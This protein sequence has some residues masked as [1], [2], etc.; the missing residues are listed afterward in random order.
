M[1]GRSQLDDN[2]ARPTGRAD[3]RERIPGGVKQAPDSAET[4]SMPIRGLRGE[5]DRLT[6]WREKPRC[7]E[8]ILRG[9]PRIGVTLSSA[10]GGVPSPS[11]APVPGRVS[12]NARRLG[13]G[14][15]M[16]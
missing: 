13:P 5:V 16:G 15:S 10:R 11:T 3:P 6:S 8:R 2:P 14:H 7:S 12:W 1:A 4:V 9:G